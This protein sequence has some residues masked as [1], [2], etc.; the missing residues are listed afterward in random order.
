MSTQAV[1]RISAGVPDGGR[2]APSGRAE[3]DDEF[4]GIIE[5]DCPKCGEPSDQDEGV[6]CSNCLDDTC[7]CGASLDDGEGYDGQC[8]S[9]ADQTEN[10]AEAAEDAANAGGCPECHR[11]EGHKLQCS[12]GRSAAPS[13][14]ERM[15]A[16]MGDGPIVTSPSGEYGFY[17]PIGGSERPESVAKHG[18]IIQVAQLVRDGSAW[19]PTPARFHV[20]SVSE[21]RDGA[22]LAIDMGADWKLSA[23]DTQALAAF[24]RTAGQNH[25]AAAKPEPEAPRPTNDNDVAIAKTIYD[26]IPFMAR[27]NMDAKARNAHAVPNGIKMRSCLAGRKRVDVTIV[28]NGSDTYDIDVVSTENEPVAAT[29]DVHV[30]QLERMMYLIG[31]GRPQEIAR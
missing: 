30:A 12:S 29:T 26:Q 5:P 27:G 3:A 20:D 2:F 6:P 16:N 24:A 25:A 11:A 28:L 21:F 17:T 13:E 14:P 7:A 15:H 23:L 22:S 19:S 18:P 1:S 9:C 4:D 8:G 10:A 31:D